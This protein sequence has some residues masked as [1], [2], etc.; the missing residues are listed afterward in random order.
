MG[1][2][3]ELGLFCFLSRRSCASLSWLTVRSVR[4]GEHTWRVWFTGLPCFEDL[5]ASS[6]LIYKDT[7]W[8][9][10]CLSWL[11]YLYFLGCELRTLPPSLYP[12]LSSTMY[13][14]HTI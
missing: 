7:H 11:F 14:L 1:L 9:S 13:T 2:G 12:S 5:A 10:V 4:C 6:L 8:R 3:L